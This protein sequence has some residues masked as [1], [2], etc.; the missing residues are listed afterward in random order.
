MTLARQ[1]Y[2]TK[3]LHEMTGWSYSTI[4]RRVRKKRLIVLAHEEGNGTRG[5]GFRFPIEPFHAMYPELKI[6]F[7]L[8]L[9]LGSGH[10]LYR[11]SA[12][13]QAAS[14]MGAR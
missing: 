8:E 11:T 7:Q 5:D 13:A 10:P 12:A 3:E 9:P 2:S 14:P 4:Y 6:P 1:T